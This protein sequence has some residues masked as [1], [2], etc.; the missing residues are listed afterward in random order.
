MVTACERELGTYVACMQLPVA[1][2]YR[3]VAQ[4]AVTAAV[5]GPLGQ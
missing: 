4:L 1:C 3:D 2:A 5:T